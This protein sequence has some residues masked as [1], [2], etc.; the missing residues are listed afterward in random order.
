MPT[1]TDAVVE[2]LA[3]DFE[4]RFRTQLVDVFSP[5]GLRRIWT[6]IGLGY[7]RL[8]MMS[9]FNEVFIDQLKAKVHRG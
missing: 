6:D 8:A 7:V 5:A 4:R 3:D 9:S 2:A 1:I